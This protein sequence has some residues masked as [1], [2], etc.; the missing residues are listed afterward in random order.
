MQKL[1]ADREHTVRETGCVAAAYFSPVSQH[2]DRSACPPAFAPPYY[3]ATAMPGEK[4]KEE[5]FSSQISL[6]E[7]LL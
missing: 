6:R 2:I 5:E 4:K 7:C 1:V 3:A